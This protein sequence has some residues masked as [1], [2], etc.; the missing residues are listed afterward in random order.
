LR[1]APESREQNER[2]V[3]NVEEVVNAISRYCG[4]EAQPTLTGFLETVALLDRD[5]PGTDSKEKKLAQDAV[6]LMSLHSSKGLEFPHVFLPG[7]EEGFLPHKKSVGENLDV[8]EERR[9]F[10]VGVTRARTRLTLLHATERKKYG[11]METRERSRFIDEI[12][13]AL[14][15]QEF[16]DVLVSEVCEEGGSLTAMFDKLMTLKGS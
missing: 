7:C 4:R 13:E 10:Y 12:P 3:E 15:R 16:R 11:K 1:R 5:E 8:D 14:L 2:R 6:M 9:L